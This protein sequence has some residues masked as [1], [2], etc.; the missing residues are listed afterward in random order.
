[1]LDISVATQVI[2]TKI[3]IMPCVKRFIIITLVC[4]DHSCTH[5]FIN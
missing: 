2:A 4:I 5:A 1:M 3:Q